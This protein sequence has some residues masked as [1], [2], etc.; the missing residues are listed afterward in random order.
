MVQDVA[1]NG[2]KVYGSKDWSG[3]KFLSHKYQLPQIMRN[4]KNKTTKTIK[5]IVQ[6]N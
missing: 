5:Y 1:R 3:L 2:L 4:Y 6:K